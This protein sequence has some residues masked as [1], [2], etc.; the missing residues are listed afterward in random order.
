MTLHFRIYKIAKSLLELVRRSYVEELKK[1][2]ENKRS[3]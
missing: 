1:I 2:F 3:F